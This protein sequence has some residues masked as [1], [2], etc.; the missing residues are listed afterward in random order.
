MTYSKIVATLAL[1]SLLSTS[2]THAL[3][4]DTDRA[5]PEWTASWSA[6]PQPIWE[7][8]FALPTNIP[9]AL[10]N[11]TVR[12]VARLSTGGKRVRVVLSN[13]Y[14][15]TPLVI[16]A[17]H[18]ALAAAGPAIA[19][20][21]DR[22]LTF[23]GRGSVTIAPGAPVVSDA[24]DLDVAP[25]TEVAI[26]M[27][28]PQTTP[29]TTFHW[30]G[31]QSAYIAPGN[32]VDAAAIKTDSTIEARLFLSTIL[33]DAPPASRVVVAFGDSITDGAGSTSNSNRRWPDILAQRLASQQVAVLNAGISGARVLA[34]KMGANALAR[35][36]RDVLGQPNVDTVILLMG[37]NDI[38]WPG[39][40]FTPYDPAMSADR[41]IAGYRQLIARARLRHVRMVGATLTPFEGALQD[42]DL[43][44]YYSEAKEQTRQAVNQ[45]IRSSGE[46]DAI[47]DF[48]AVVRDPRHPQR[49]LPVFDSGDHL[50]PGD[51][52][53]QAMANAIDLTTLLRKH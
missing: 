38:S 29:L 5:A 42:T 8:G 53:Y 17:A 18:I 52:G 16:G 20:R 46:F 10:S 41:L 12:Q 40:S 15:T 7:A 11:Q 6:S 9:D 21:S 24:V 51:I 19:A 32:L 31:K 45:W 13:E 3:A 34:D 33:V 2:A 30:D 27:F 4:A 36:D 49:F 14:G 26:S 25:L 43:K 23:G 39:S 37:I 44:N 48:D 47:I 28:L 22:T 1:A 35:F 50:H